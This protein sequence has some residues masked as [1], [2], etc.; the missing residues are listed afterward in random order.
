M[1]HHGTM[2]SAEGNE[3]LSVRALL[4]Q[5]V[6][7]GPSRRILCHWWKSSGVCVRES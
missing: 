4:I 6:I 2:H 5:E 7:L 3:L 1:L